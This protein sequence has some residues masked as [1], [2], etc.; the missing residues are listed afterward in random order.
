M[1]KSTAFAGL[2]LA[3]FA[4]QP[5]VA[6]QSLDHIVAVVNDGVILES[7][8]QQAT[9]RIKQQYQIDSA[10]MPKNA[11]RSQVLDHLIMR[12]LQ[13]QSAKHAGLHVDDGAVNKAIARV[14]KQ[15]N[16]STQQFQQSLK[17]HGIKLGQF[18]QQLHDQLLVQKLQRKAVASR[19]A[20]SN[21]DVDNYLKNQSLQLKANYQYH[22][23]HILIAVDS[24]ADSKT[25]HAAKQLADKIRQT[26]AQGDESFAHLAITYSD[27]RKA[28][29]GGDLGWIAG[30]AMPTLFQ[31]VVPKLQTGDISK[32]F[33]GPGGFHL[34]KLAGMRQQGGPVA[35]Q[36]PNLVKEV[37]IRR[38]LL[39]PNKIRTNE[40]TR[41]L[42]QQIYTRL[43]A[44]GNFAE[45]ARKDSDDTHTSNQGGDLGW[46]AITEL[47]KTLASQVQQLQP[48]DLSQP[49]ETTKGWQLVKL[50]DRQTRDKTKQHR[51]QR[52][53]QAIGNRKMQEQVG[54]WLNQLRDQAYVDIRMQG[55]RHQDMGG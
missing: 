24:N 22:L 7:Q 2:L 43:Q 46:V 14:A 45:L 13:M 35:K 41:K 49:F 51:R 47:P 26:A 44:G 11:L 27:G 25:L 52:A 33:R 21:Q 55:Y 29:K 53:R 28:L 42:A 4:I 37:H 48:G 54:I 15:N 30:R 50:V 19:V 20:V 38:I 12:K 10:D 31:D 17:Q 23:R 6:Q 9:K 8:L 5:S 3:F 40:Q 39:Q 16:M 18:R 32:V 36:Q 34:I 1:K